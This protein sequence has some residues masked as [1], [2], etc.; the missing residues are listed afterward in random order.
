M[1][2]NELLAKPEDKTEDVTTY[3][4]AIPATWESLESRLAG[5]DWR[6]A[7]GPSVQ[8]FN[9]GYPVEDTL[10]QQPGANDPRTGPGF[11]EAPGRRRTGGPPTPTS[12][13]RYHKR[14]SGDIRF[15][16]RVVH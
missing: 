11:T 9:F 14:H 4:H 2:V 16:V 5:R 3:A 12:P 1:D 10:V 13:S 15:A 8:V 7:L 6:T